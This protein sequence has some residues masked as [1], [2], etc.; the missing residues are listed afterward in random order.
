MLIMSKD[1]TKAASVLNG[2]PRVCQSIDWYAKGQ[3]RTVDVDGQ[4]ITI[5]FVG[6]KG[7]RIRIA[8]SAPSGAVFRAADEA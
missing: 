7:R 8:I 6:R 1:A 4:Q 5:R 2:E 3:C